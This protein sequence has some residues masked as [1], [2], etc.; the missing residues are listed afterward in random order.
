MLRP[1]RAGQPTAA[2]ERR[3]GY[4]ERNGGFQPGEEIQGMEKPEQTNFN[5]HK[6]KQTLQNTVPEGLPPPIHHCHGERGGSMAGAAGGQRVRARVCC[7]SGFV[8][9]GGAHRPPAPPQGRGTDI[10]IST[11]MKL[12]CR[13]RADVGRGGGSWSAGHRGVMAP[14]DTPVP[15]VP[16]KRRRRRKHKAK[17][18]QRPVDV[19]AFCRALGM[20]R[21]GLPGSWMCTGQQM[22]VALPALGWLCLLCPLH[23]RSCGDNK[24]TGKGRTGLSS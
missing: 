20:A 5:L 19:V 11:L 22:P 12:V 2:R 21:C 4:G 23:A 16:T 24:H 1:A 17:F 9:T 15:A 14:R 8:S 13:E 7:D 18:G 3:S 6:Q 10:L